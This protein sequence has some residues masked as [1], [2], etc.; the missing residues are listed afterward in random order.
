MGQFQVETLTPDILITTSLTDDLFPA[1]YCDGF[2]V[3]AP[4]EPAAA[5]SAASASRLFRRSGSAAICLQPHCLSA[6]VSRSSAAPA[7]LT[8]LCASLRLGIC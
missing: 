1:H 5:A 6:D 4:R 8:S 2:T 3:R 7:E